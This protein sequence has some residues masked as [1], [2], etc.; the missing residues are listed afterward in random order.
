[1]K[2]A[3]E[4]RLEVRL[5]EPNRRQRLKLDREELIQYLQEEGFRPNPELDTG[6]YDLYVNPQTKQFLLWGQER[7][8]TALKYD[9]F[10]GGINFNPKDLDRILDAYSLPS[11]MD[12]GKSIIGLGV[13]P[14]HER[15]REL[16]ELCRSYRTVSTDRALHCIGFYNGKK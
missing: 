9:S 2:E 12:I 5:S 10:I 1:M 11:I 13:N 3:L 6:K 4:R 8:S 14:L 7:T 16:T 15:A